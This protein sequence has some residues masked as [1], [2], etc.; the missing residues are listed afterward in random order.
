MGGPGSPPGQ[1][2]PVPAL[3]GVKGHRRRTTQRGGLFLRAPPHDS[4]KRYYGTFF[5]TPSG[6]LVGAPG[7]A[8]GHGWAHASLSRPL[9]SSVPPRLANGRQG[10]R[11]LEPRQEGS[12]G[13]LAG[14]GLKRR[15][16]HGMRDVGPS[17]R[18]KAACDAGRTGSAEVGRAGRVGLE[19]G[20]RSSR[21]A[22]A[23]LPLRAQLHQRVR[24]GRVV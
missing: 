24:L 4:Q 9:C 18:V 3:T 17:W 19:F 12:S 15:A 16:A 20:H 11:C 6:V 21:P 1:G 23:P 7:R 8:I 22:N 13:L 10:R 2:V 14:L 5:H